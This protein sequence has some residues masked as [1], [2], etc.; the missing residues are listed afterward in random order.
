MHHDARIDAIRA[1]NR[2]YT[3]RIGVL[4]EGLLGSPYSLAESR[5]LWELAHADALPASALAR[6][7]DLDP[8]YLSRLLRGLK[9]RGLVRGERDA[10]D[11][12]SRLL[13]LT[14]AGRAAYAPLDSASRGQVA[15]LLERLDDASQQ[16]LVAAMQEIRQLLGTTDAERPSSFVL[17]PDRAGDMGW[18]VAR[19]G[20]LYAAEHGWNGRFEALV[21]RLVADFVER[22]DPQREHCWI[23]ERDGAN[24]GCVFLVQA[25]DEASGAPEPGTA[26]LRMLLVEPAARGL[27][28]GEALVRECERYARA[29]GYR[30]IRL[31]TQ[32]MLTAARR[33]Y[34]KAGY[35]QVAS[36][37]HT[38]FGHDLV[39]ETWELALED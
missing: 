35:R 1:F 24:V 18:V 14:E 34:L 8:G 5:V 9:A 25:R 32:S 39:A 26:Q 12:R 7:L 29:A 2:D 16:R 38:S 28:L 15:A 37:P 4:D 10:Q 22:H 27:Q 11:G 30:R 21:A 36:E 6:A 19:H 31:W 3:R 20:A 33:L 13:A 23:A 17:R